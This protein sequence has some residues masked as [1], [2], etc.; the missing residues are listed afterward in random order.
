MGCLKMA[1]QTLT[2]EDNMNNYN[3]IGKLVYSHILASG[4]TTIKS[5]AV[6]DAIIKEALAAQSLSYQA[7]EFENIYTAVLSY[8]E[9][10]TPSGTSVVT[11]I[12]DEIDYDADNAE[13]I[14]DMISE[15]EEIYDELEDVLGYVDELVD[16]TNYEITLND[17][18]KYF[19]Q[20][21]P[22]V[23]ESD[24]FASSLAGK[25]NDLKV[26]ISAIETL[27]DEISSLVFLIKE[28]VD[29]V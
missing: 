13:E 20:D 5:K 7:S 22:S 16:D 24:D 18:V 11:D 27:N 23:F 19:E 10:I 25:L 12:S 8:M 26:H 2:F 9:V 15:F 6:L 4:Y 28:N 29:M 21:L 14:Q 3:L 1:S 17:C